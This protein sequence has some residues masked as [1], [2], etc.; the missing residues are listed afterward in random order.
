M[1]FFL[2]SALSMVLLSAASLP[3]ANIEGRYVEARTADVFTGACYA[4]SE[5]NL[6]GHEAVF[7]WVIDK[8][9]YDGVA[10]DGLG[11]MSA[12]KASATLGDIHNGAYPVKSVI[13]LD[14][15]ATA[16]QKVALMAFAKRMSG[17]LLT[18]VVDVQTRPIQMDVANNNI[19]SAQVKFTAGELTKIETRPLA[20]NDQIC[21][22]EEVWYSPLTKLDHAMPAYALD[23]RYSGDALGTKWSSAEKRSAFVGTFHLSE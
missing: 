6:M 21:R 15:K 11:V 23:N 7:G 18:D 22:H 4:N 12:I 2:A 5:V 3:K 20:T 14:E 9:S 8:G 10:L 17:D 13:V 16:K 1:R 19:H